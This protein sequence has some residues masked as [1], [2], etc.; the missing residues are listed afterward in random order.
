MKIINRSMT[1]KEIQILMMIAL[2]FSATP[3][4]SAQ[5]QKKTKNENGVTTETVQQAIS[6][7]F[8]NGGFESSK[9]KDNKYPG[10]SWPGERGFK[11]VADA[12]SGR[13]AIHI[14]VPYPS[15]RHKLDISSLRGNY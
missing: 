1:V 9:G 12:H 4:V 11:V 13:R 6:V 15:L 8:M 2:L 7:P 5:E 14:G 3:W 10:W